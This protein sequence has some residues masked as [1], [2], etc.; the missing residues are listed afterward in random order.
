[1]FTIPPIRVGEPIHH[2]SLTVFP[3]FAERQ[4]RVDYLLSDEAIQAGTVTI[5]EISD[6][7]SVPELLV[8]NRGE[9]RVLFLEGEE[10]AGAKQNRILNTS[11]LLPARSK[12]NIPV[13]CVERG[14]WSYKSRHFGSE[15]RHSSSK[16]RHFLKA[17][18][19]KSTIGGMGHRSDQGKVW[20]EVDKQQATLGVHSP[21]AAMADSFELHKPRIE[22]T[23]NSFNTRKAPRGWRWP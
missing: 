17:S 1:M 7:G 15:G 2:E 23:P 6:T 14:R 19:T 4:G 21:T 20:E 18:V 16:L 10:L 11:L 13:S 3:L 8:E 5:Q 12:T 9:V 22:R